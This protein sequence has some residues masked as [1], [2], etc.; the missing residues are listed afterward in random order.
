MTFSSR[1][2]VFGALCL[3]PLMC[4]SQMA[5]RIKVFQDEREVLSSGGSS[6]PTFVLK[7]TEFRVEVSPS[8]CAPTIASVPN[9]EIAKQIAEKPLIYAERWAYVMAA[10][11]ED[12]DKLLWWARTEFDSELRN[13]PSPNT[14]AG[15]QYLTLCEE[16][17]FCPN[18]YPIYSSGHPFSNSQTGSK[19]IANFKRLDDTRRLADAKGKT[20]LSVIYTLWRS[21]PSEYPMADPRALLFR[22]NFVYL[23]F[24]E[25]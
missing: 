16:L 17:R 18:P 13:P 25:D 15:K 12:G 22:P 8:A 7:A 19:S 3:A 1:L 4:M 20:L 10:Y 23:Q 24:L 2:A 5:C 21:L 14:F 9:T 6:I 11:P